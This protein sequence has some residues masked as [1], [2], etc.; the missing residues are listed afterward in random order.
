MT[1]AHY[2]EQSVC[3]AILLDA[4]CLP[5]VTSILTAGDFVIEAD[6]AIYE[7][8]VEL[9]RCGDPVDP[10]T[11]VNRSH[12]KVSREYAMQL[13]Q[14]TP[15]A[16]N[17]EAHA[18]LTRKESMRRAL[19]ALGTS[20]SERAAG[21]DEP[22]ELIGDIQRKLER[23]EA[24]DTAR[25][26]ATTSEAVMAFYD[27]LAALEA[28]GGGFVR[29]GYRQ[30][31][32][33]LGGGLLNSGLY[34]LAA[35]PGM[36][37]TT[38]ALNILDNINGPALFVSLEMDMEQITAKRLSRLCGIP[39]DRLM[40]NQLSA[41]E[42]GMM[43][44]ASKRL[45]TSQVHVNRKPFAT[46]ADIETMARKVKDIRCVIVDYFGLIRPPRKLQKRYDEMTEVSAGLK[47]LAR[48]LK[49]PVLC[50]AQLNRENMGRSNKRPQLSDLRDTGALE[51]DADGVMFLHREDYYEPKQEGDDADQPSMM[52][53]I[54]EKNRH[55]RTGICG[56]AFYL[57]TS[58]VLSA[59]LPE[60][61][62]RSNRILSEL[63]EA[64]RSIKQANRAAR[65]TDRG[66]EQMRIAEQEGKKCE[67]APF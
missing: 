42:Y 41:E 46:V 39:S 48:S 7:A 1:D 6:R 32:E 31:D 49:V 20:T 62:G 33:L 26:L 38:V 19:Y 56:A 61:R 17:V 21:M 22:R 58:K 57:S 59:S 11:I 52:E 51:Q 18:E 12:G 23:I 43:A 14:L 16:A 36:G 2:S 64:G 13:M 15:T 54:L 44:E 9:A 3:G 40:T 37:K 8:A 45:S 4:Q 47:A 60:K 55:G 27:R 29:T 28:G 30:L 50:L 10:V 35:R 53:I 63:S 24:Q 67:N 65:Q 5:V 66:E 34:L 25:E